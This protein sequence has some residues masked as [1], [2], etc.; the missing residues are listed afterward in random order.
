GLSLDCSVTLTHSWPPPRSRARATRAPPTKTSLL[1]QPTAS[2]WLSSL[3]LHH[4]VDGLQ[5]AQQA[6]EPIE[7]PVVRPV[8]ERVIGVL[9]HF[10]EERV[11]PDRHGST[12]PRGP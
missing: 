5:L 1:R 2:R 12:R 3:P 10:H 7:R 4:S 6:L 9:V 8:A 11:D